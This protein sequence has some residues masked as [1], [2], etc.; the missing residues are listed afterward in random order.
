MNMWTRRIEVWLAATVAVVAI[1]VAAV[2]CG[3][4]G[5]EADNGNEAADPGQVVT[6]EGGPTEE[7][8]KGD[9]AE[10]ENL[11]GGYVYRREGGIAGFCDVITVLAGT[12]SVA[13]CATDPPEII[14]EVT[15]TN[16][17]SQTVNFWLERL[18]PFDHEQTDD[19]A[20]D[21]MSIRLTFE[22][23]GDEEATAEDRAEMEALALEVLRAVGGQ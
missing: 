1:A 21:G 22:G 4:R 9:A 11:G 17:Q 14:G 19:A 3:G 20:A 16:D 2:A 7:P 18:A 8:D 6:V 15:L 23:Q 10:L 12:A 5:N 13:T